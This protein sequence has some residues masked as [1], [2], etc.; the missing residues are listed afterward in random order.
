MRSLGEG[1]AQSLLQVRESEGGFE[2]V[3]AFL[4]LGV[5][6]GRELQEVRSNLGETTEYFGFKGEMFDIPEVKLCPVPTKPVPI[7]I[8]GHSEPALKRAARMGDG[9]IAAGADFEGLKR[10]IG[11]VNELRKE[12]GRDHLPFEFSVA[13][14][15][16][17]SLDG[18]KQYQDLGITEVTLA[19]RNVYEKEV[20]D[21]SVEEKIG[22][23]DW[24]A[25]EVMS[26]V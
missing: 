15:E 7:L 19:F 9:W 16:A 17:Y 13:G 4:A 8:G 22:V 12:Y 14:A 23:M 10:M 6:Q 20:D 11:R 18:I 1:E 2:N 5:F 3:D 25:N 24:Y 26:K 21:K